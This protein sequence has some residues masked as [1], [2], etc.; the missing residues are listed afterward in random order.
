MGSGEG[1]GGG[2]GQLLGGTE[3]VASLT[4]DPSSCRA[5]KEGRGS[6][7]G[8]SHR[9]KGEA[10]RQESNGR[11]DAE[12]REGRGPWRTSGQVRK[13]CPARIG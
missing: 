3:D 6:G 2:F 9:D 11:S 8:K 7:G 10:G 5:G 13:P 4:P 12:G 1:K